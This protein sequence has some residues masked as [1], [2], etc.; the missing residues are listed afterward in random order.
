M[1]DIPKLENRLP[2][3][4]KEAFHCPHCHVYADQ[5]WHAMVPTDRWSNDCP[6]YASCVACCKHCGQH[7]IWVNEKMMLPDT[8]NAPQPN[9]DMSG[10]IKKIY[11]EAAQILSNSPRAT[12]ALLRLAL[13]ELCSK[14]LKCEGKNLQGHIDF[15]IAEEKLSSEVAEAMDTMRIIG[16]EAVHAGTIDLRDN[17][18]TAAYM[19]TLIN[20]IAKELITQPKE[21]KKM[22]A[23]LPKSKKRK[24]TQ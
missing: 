20:Y 23:A 1:S 3:F 7:S 6:P 16:N 12:A 8:G 15:L 22:Y 11:G 24:G 17:A 2:A 14:Q 4:Q 13:E 5:E 18:D 9:D 21:R 10:D 19:F